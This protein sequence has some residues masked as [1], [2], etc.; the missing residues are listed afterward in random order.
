MKESEQFRILKDFEHSKTGTLINVNILVAGF[1][2]PT[3][4]LL[5]IAR[6]VKSIRTAIQIWGRA[7]RKHGDKHTKILDMCSV[8]ENCGLP[9]D[10]RDFN[11]VRKPKIKGEKKELDEV[12]TKQCPLCKEVSPMEEFVVES[13][14]TPESIITTIYCP[15]CEKLCD[16]NRVDLTQVEELNKIEDVEVKVLN[17]VERKRGIEDLIYECTTANTTWA[18]YILNDLKRTNRL[19]YLDQQLQRDVTPK[20]KWKHI[21][22]LY[23]SAQV[24]LK[25]N[26][27]KG[28]RR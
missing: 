20:T 8:Y 12:K 1:D 2:D 17:N 15:K 16:E 3:I 5:I 24:D 7:L 26:K 22:S 9:K 10:I 21:M 14:T 19:M 27:N 4:D 25:T 6:P 13:E 11:A 23:E 18:Y 28:S